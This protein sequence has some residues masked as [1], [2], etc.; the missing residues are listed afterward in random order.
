MILVDEEAK[1]IFCGPSRTGYLAINCS[2]MTAN[3]GGLTTTG[4][5]FANTRWTAS[6]EVVLQACHTFNVE[7]FSDGGASGRGAW[8][9]I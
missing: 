1:G 7:A 6:L 8:G 5:D 4:D 9:F 2:V 3:A